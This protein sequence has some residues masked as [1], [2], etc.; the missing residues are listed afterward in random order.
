MA[1]KKR[2]YTVNGQMMG[3]EE[4]GVKK[5]FLTDHL[6]SITA[7]IDQNQNRTFETR[8]SAFGRNNWSTGTGC[9]FGWVGSFGYRET[10]LF[11]MSHYVRARHYSYVTGGWSTV[12]PL[13]PS[14]ASYGYV[15]GRA[16]YAS[17]P[18]GLA[19]GVP[20]IELPWDKICPPPGANWKPCDSLP[21]GN[22]PNQGPDAGRIRIGDFGKP[23]GKPDDIKRCDPK[24][25]IGSV[26]EKRIEYV[27]GIIAALCG[28][29][30]PIPPGGFPYAGVVKTFYHSIL[31]MIAQGPALPRYMKTPS[32]SVIA[33]S[34]FYWIFFFIALFIKIKFAGPLEMAM[35][36]AGV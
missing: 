31:F 25:I 4:G 1:M 34:T 24:T 29:G 7:E 11:H 21:R 6:G 36:K 26:F 9:G 10:G 28:K 27:K 16:S 15:G 13:W 3:Y 22:C 14:E 32:G 8:Y 33:L 12:D 17:D 2:F 19:Q 35:S 30:G 20:S 5:D 18:S 23:G